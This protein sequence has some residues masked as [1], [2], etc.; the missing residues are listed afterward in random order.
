MTGLLKRFWTS[1]VAC[2]RPKNIAWQVFAVAL[3]YVLV[4]SGFDWWWFEHTRG[5]I[6]QVWLFPAAIIGGLVPIAL[7]VILFIEGQVKR[8]AQ[9]MRAAWA[10]AHAAI[11]GLG[12]SMAYKALSGR[13]PPPFLSSC[14]GLADSSG[15]FYFGIL[16]KG[17]FWGWP[18]SH[19]TVAFA[20]AITLAILYR[21][22][23]FVRW[24]AL[25]VAFYVGIGVSTN[26]HWFSDVIAGAILG[27][28]IGS[29]VAASFKK[30]NS[31]R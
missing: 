28:I 15:Q 17:T 24:S 12:I 25:L 1:I 27:I 23:P 18:S 20:V 10:S 11:V 9:L 22:R 5:F 30:G 26:I 2:Y 14:Q 13:L 29:A 21:N 19:T 8:K 7:P 4:V 6:L 31:R 16:Q 3:T